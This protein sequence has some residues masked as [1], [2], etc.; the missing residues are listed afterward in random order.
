MFS[1]T[2]SDRCKV[3]KTLRSAARGD[4]ARC[5]DT[6]GAMTTPENEYRF[7]LSR[8]KLLAAA[9]AAMAATALAA[10]GDA[11]SAAPTSRGA[12]DP[13]ATPPVSG[14]HLQFGA[15]ASS[16]MVVSWHTLQPVRRPRV[17]LGHLDGALEQTI[18]ADE[19]SYTD[20][21]SNQVVYAYHAKVRGLRPDTTY[22]Y[23]AMH[24]GAAPEFGTFRTSPR[25]RRAF[26][27]TSFGDQGT[28][29][30]GKRYVP[31]AGVSLPNL[32][33]VNDNLGSPAGSD[34]TL[35]VERLRPLFHLFNGDLCYA[36]LADDR[37]RTWWDFWNN[38]SRSARN[39]PWMPSPGNHENELGNG[40]IG[41]RAYQ[42]YFSL[43]SAGGQ[44]DVTRGLWYAFTV[45]SMRVVS[46]AND[47]IVYQDGGSSYVRGY[48]QGAQKAWLERELAA[49]RRDRGIDWLV[50]CMHQVAISTAD[51][52][53]GADLG[54]R[55]EWLP[56]FDKY[57]VDLVV[58]G[59]EH[60]YERSH[61]LRGQQTNATLTP[62]P[63]A[64]ATDVIDTTRGTV[65]MVIGG[66][67]TSLPSNQ[68]FF[69]PPACRVITAVGER[70]ATTGKR[71]PIYV[72]EDAPWSAVRNAAHSYGF[73]AFH[74]EPGTRPGGLTTI[75][76]T[77]YDVVGTDG[78]LAPFET[79]TLRRRRRD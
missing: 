61:P 31:P 60:H 16:E 69:D 62:I 49:A 53:N 17:A 39:R 77:Y 45:G 27:F 38:N 29:T 36:N 58:C 9:G 70:D 65:H 79:F 19:A 12:T 67:G 54:I 14:M 5:W 42:T 7:E 52:F 10:P 75:T 55:Q 33:F 2:R 63:A 44:T 57:A 47:D 25:G 48:S 46:I 18:A 23:A 71:P 1:A 8:R 41:Y 59:H 66:G 51:K 37:V 28:P 30:L 3:I 13:L 40:P 32:P 43:P 73:A 78:R 6:F 15:D 72:H 21:K 11:D 26:T 4:S 50:I 68:L 56:L 22:L 64:T 34:T 35:G 20:A 76:V 24:D 74:L